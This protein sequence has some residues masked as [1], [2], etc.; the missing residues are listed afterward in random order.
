MSG[1]ERTSTVI[2]VLSNIPILFTTFNKAI[3]K[4]CTYVSIYNTLDI[5]EEHNWIT[6]WKSRIWVY[7]LLHQLVSTTEVSVLFLIEGVVTKLLFEKRTM[8]QKIL[9]M[10]CFKF[11][12]LFNKIL[13]CVSYYSAS[14]DTSNY[15]AK[16]EIHFYR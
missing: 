4:I 11:Y 8:G 7:Q 13:L 6:V 15:F 16:K 1:I 12:Q 5:K 14:N 10:W 9:G 3:L 2:L